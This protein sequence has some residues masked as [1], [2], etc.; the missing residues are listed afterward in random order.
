MDCAE[1]NG[2]LR[3]LS[4][5]K[6]RVLAGQIE[7]GIK[8]G[9]QVIPVSL[10]NRGGAWRAVSGLIMLSLLASQVRPRKTRF[11]SDFPALELIRPKSVRSQPSQLRSRNPRHRLGIART[12]L[13]WLR[14]Y[15]L[16]TDQ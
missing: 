4:Y 15:R 12:T 16:G 11:C 13:G 9:L 1:L 6:F 3:Q 14:T 2:D 5:R 10:L 7:T 8:A